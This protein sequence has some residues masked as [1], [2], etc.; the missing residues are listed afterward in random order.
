[1]KKGGAPATRK[2]IRFA[3]AEAKRKPRPIPTPAILAVSLDET[4]AD[5]IERGAVELHSMA[6]APSQ[7]RVADVAARILEFR[8]G[9]REHCA[10]DSKIAATQDAQAIA[11]REPRPGEDLAQHKKN[12]R[13]RDRLK[14]AQMRPLG[15]PQP[16]AFP[17]T[18]ERRDEILAS[19]AAWREFAEDLQNKGDARGETWVVER[20]RHLQELYDNGDMPTE[21]AAFR[22]SINQ[23]MLKRI[24]PYETRREGAALAEAELVQIRAR[25]G[26][27]DHGPD[28]P[29]TEAARLLTISWKKP[30]GKGRPVSNGNTY[31]VKQAHEMLTWLMGN[32]PFGGRGGKLARFTH[33][34]LR[35]VDPG[36]FQNGA[37]S[38]AHHRGRIGERFFR[39]FTDP[40]QDFVG[41]IKST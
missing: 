3:G 9:Y 28:E 8:A 33:E 20:N 19:D 7:I 2:L 36:R 13:I 30:R 41:R 37:V 34:L 32:K 23:I 26:C 16:R 27:T 38:V 22:A 5:V 1:M 25:Y 24:D 17:L 12:K 18:A 4:D 15:A 35:I 31:A 14:P 29:L 11:L 6:G 39:P 10:R 21:E 40:S